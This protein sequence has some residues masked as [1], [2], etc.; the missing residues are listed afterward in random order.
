MGGKA[1]KDL[2]QLTKGFLDGLLVVHIAVLRRSSA[3]DELVE[4]PRLLRSGLNQQGVSCPISDQSTA[5]A[6]ISKRSE[7]MASR[8]TPT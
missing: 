1:Y 5:V 6:S 2:P 4:M 7:G 8:V 3:K